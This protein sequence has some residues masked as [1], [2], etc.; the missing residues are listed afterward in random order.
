MV[1]ILKKLLKDTAFDITFNKLESPALAYLQ[2][3]LPVSLPLEM[4]PNYINLVKGLLESYK[5]LGLSHVLK[6]SF[7]TLAHGL[8]S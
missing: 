3:L 8:L 6:Y 5:N 7:L 2:L 1:H 4:T